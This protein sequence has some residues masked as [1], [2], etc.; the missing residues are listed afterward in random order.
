[1]SGER[2]SLSIP[3]AY[4][5][6]IEHDHGGMRLLVPLSG[7][8]DYRELGGVFVSFGLS[9]MQKDALAGRE[10]QP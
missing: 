8:E 3:Y 9:L 1:M 6:S 7:R 10:E 4:R 2:L 5:P